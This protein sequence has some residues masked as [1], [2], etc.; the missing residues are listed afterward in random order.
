MK[1]LMFI[2][3]SLIIISFIVFGA[4]G[5]SGGKSTPSTPKTET[6]Q[7]QQPEQIIKCSELSSI[8]E[9]VPCRIKKI[10]QGEETEFNPEECRSFVG[11]KKDS[12]LQT[13]SAAQSCWSTDKNDERIGCIKKFLKISSIN[14][15]KDKCSKLENTEKTQCISSLKEKVFT[16]AKFRFYNLEERA[17]YF[18][19]EGADEKTVSDFIISMELKKH[20]FNNAISI[21]EK[22]NV[23]L[24]T[25]D[26]WKNFIDEIRAQIQ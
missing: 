6:P 26:I 22:K 3:T 23:V 9:R 25:K 17:E 19:R 2:F 21:E 4:G 11:T 13:Y 20:E 16:I 18:M 10:N 15:E 14:E 1:K 7:I 8:Q 12:C 24:E 5:G